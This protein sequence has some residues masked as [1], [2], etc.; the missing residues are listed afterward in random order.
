MKP[1]CAVMKLTLAY[2][3]RPLCRYKSG[4]PVSRYLRPRWASDLVYLAMKPAEWIF[5]SALVRLDPGAPES[6]I[7]RMYR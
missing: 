1:S 7:D 6:R 3:R 2:G 4:L 5:Y